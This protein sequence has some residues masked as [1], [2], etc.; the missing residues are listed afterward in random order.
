MYFLKYFKNFIHFLLIIFLLCLSLFLILTNIIDWYYPDAVIQIEFIKN[1]NFLGSI[2]ANWANTTIGRPG[3]VFWINLWF[4]IFLMFDTLS[5]YSLFLYKAL[6]FFTVGL[7]FFFLINTL[8]KQNSLIN[9]YYS[10]IIFNIFLI[11]TGQ[12]NLTYV[13][14][15]D[16]SIYIMS[17]AYFNFLI[18]FL[19]KMHEHNFK[20]M[21]S[22]L[23]GL[24]FLL[25][26][27]SSY[28][29]LVTGG[30]IL[31]FS[32]YSIKEI[33]FFLKTPKKII[34][35]FI[36]FQKISTK[37]K[38]K[39]K[40]FNIFLILY[41]ISAIINL[42]SPSMAIREQIW[43][44]DSSIFL[45]IISSI[46]LLEFLIINYW[47]YKYLI[48]SG[49]IFIIF[50]FFK[51]EVKISNTLIILLILTAPLIVLVSNSLAYLASSLHQGWDVIFYEKIIF[52]KSLL[53]YT[54]Y[55]HASAA[56][57]FVYYNLNALT[58]YIFIG[59]L[60]TKIKIKK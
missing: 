15:M 39:N 3:G 38:V 27:N 10:L 52:T 31:V 42:F 20:K 54:D 29:H 41:L 9:F 1:T 4:S 40:Y 14:E 23:F 6:S 50:K 17:I 33:L 22:I 55:K 32:F 48:V 58:S 11:L 30:L 35:N 34:Q 25:Y 16:L 43:P 21:Y 13:Y 59:I 2:Y 28:A 24:F 5:I 47:G 53:P 60:F 51:V 7:S 44:S 19:L 12:F 49:L 26:N 46:P 18:F 8:N 37:E 56:R 57:H 45:G 36:L